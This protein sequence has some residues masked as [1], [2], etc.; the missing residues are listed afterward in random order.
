[1]ADGQ[2]P[3]VATLPRPAVAWGRALEGWRLPSG[4]QPAVG[5]ALRHS[6]QILSSPTGQVVRDALG[7]DGALLDVGCGDGWFCAGFASA[8]P[9]T[10]VEENPVLAG[11]ARA[12]GVAVV[13]RPWRQCAAEVGACDVVC[14]AH[15]VYDVPD[16]V[17]FLRA[18]HDHARGAVVVELTTSH[19]CEPLRPLLERFHGL[20]PPAGPGLDAFLRV[21]RGALGVQ[22]HVEVWRRP[23]NPYPDMAAFLEH[24]KAL[25][26]LD[27]VAS[28]ELR[29][30]LD[31]RYTVDLDG[32]VR[33]APVE[34]ATVWW[35][36]G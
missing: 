24:T 5:T 36:A 33:T 15:A 27:A 6:G 3:V 20:R 29:G 32:S 2:D 31:S 12:A 18:A 23:G 22:P 7:A 34:V 21:V 1:M 17:P 28:G 14:S 10:G 4:T 9:V 8:H 16:L 13:Q 30:A 26:S 19:P 11:Q 35:P 25:L